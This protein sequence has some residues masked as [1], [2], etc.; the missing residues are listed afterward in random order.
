MNHPAVR[1]LS[2][3]LACSSVLAGPLAAQR[4]AAAVPTHARTRADA[5][6]AQPFTTL[7]GVRELAD[8]R[9]VVVDR[10]EKSI[11][12]LDLAAGSAARVG[13]EG[14]GPNEYRQPHSAFSLP[15]DST[16]VFDMGNMRH[17][18]VTPEGAVARTFS[19]M[20]PE[21]ESMRLL[22]ARGT[23]GA[24]NLYFLDRGLGA[25]P[26][27]V[28]VA[29]DSGT[30][31]RYDP[32]TK[33]VAT[34]ATV[35]LPET[36]I[37]A[38][39]SAGQRQV[40][41]RSTPFA[42]Q[43]DWTA[44]LDGRLAIVRH[45]PYRVE[46]IAPSGQRVTGP[47]VSHEPLRVTEKD[48]E[49]WRERSRNPAGGVRIVV[50]GRPGGGSA[51]APMTTGARMAE[52]DQ[53]PEWKPPFLAGAAMVATDGRLWVQRTTPAGDDVPRYDIFDGF[54][55]L[56]ARATLP[57]ASRLVGFGRNSAYV[58]RKDENDLEYL[59]RYRLP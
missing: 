53:W 26:G 54:G 51:P 47:S 57:S 7:A 25:T 18:V 3:A 42:A 36:R 59:E 11:Q 15:G 49:A 39:G 12:L 31:L 13:H 22:L 45:E 4:G 52:P 55:R 10:G 17:M 1:S 2:I 9:L 50:G 30:V 20:D 5:R 28:P 21:S 56:V 19:T 33:S 27:A 58:V 35:G 44:G 37:D 29:R 38:S 34:V 40:M 41:I 16:L 24:G 8:G 48:R 23:D 6:H 32:R 46:W 14:G 43:D